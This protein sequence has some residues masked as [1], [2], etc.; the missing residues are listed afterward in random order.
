MGKEHVYDLTMD[1]YEEP[2]FVA[3][4]LVVHNTYSNVETGMSVFM[5]NTES[6]REELTYQTLTNKV[7]PIVAVANEFYKPGKNV[8]VNTKDKLNYQLNN[9]N[10]LDIPI[11]R[12]HKQLE[13]KDE[14]N[15]MDVL[16]QLGEKGF[17]IPL[18]MWAAAAKVDIN[19]LYEDLREDQKIKEKLAS[20]TGKPVEMDP[21]AGE[22]M[23]SDSG[24]GDSDADWG[25]FASLHEQTRPIRRKPLLNRTFN[26]DAHEVKEKTKTGKDK[27]VYNQRQA[28]AKLN[29]AILSVV[30]DLTNDPN[31]R[32]RAMQK[33]RAK[34]G[35]IFPHLLDHVQHLGSHH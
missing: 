10:D 30:R 26:G 4:G 17:P 33:V 34:T 25:E 22:G 24:S 7:F 28:T 5:E 21:A 35:G 20:I 3:N 12:W 9:H 16:T 8:N 29:D 27:S 31:A 32:R 14:A 1:K 2:A 11:V 19:S 15:I 23:G 6:L 13:A 18:R